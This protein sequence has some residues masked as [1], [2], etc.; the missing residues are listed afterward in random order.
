MRQLIFSLLAAFTLTGCSSLPSLSTSSVFGGGEKKTPAK[1]AV[2]STDTPSNRAYRLGAVSARAVRCGYNINPTK[3]KSQFLETEAQKGL[4]V[5]QIGKL[6]RIHT[7]AFNGVRKA[8]ATQENYCSIS[9]TAVIK[10]S[11]D[12]YIAGD[13]SAPAKKKV[14]GNNQGGMFDWFDTAG[15]KKSGPKFGSTEWWEKQDEYSGRL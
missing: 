12:R 2:K 1:V 3:L 4:T 6:D 7:T 14:A 13:F 11:L 5:D 15:E 10:K 8:A 9:K